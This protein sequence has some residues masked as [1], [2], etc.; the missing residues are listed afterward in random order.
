[1]KYL[2]CISCLLINIFL[3]SCSFQMRFFK[4]VN[5]AYLDK[6]LTISPLSAYQVLGL[7]ANGARGETLDQMLSTLGNQNLNELNLINANIIA[8]INSLSSVEIAN[9][10]MTRVKPKQAFMNAAVVYGATVESLR[11]VE[12]V[13]SWCN[14]K[15]HGTIPTIIDSL[16]PNTIMLLLNALYFKGTWRTEFDPKN[17]TKKEF[18][19]LDKTVKRVDT[20]L[21][22]EKLNY[23]EDKEV[24]VVELPYTKDSMSALILLPREGIN[25]NNFIDGLDDDKLQKYIKRMYEETV[26][27]KLPKFTLEFSAELNKVLQSMGM[28]LPFKGSADFTG[29][30][31]G[32]AYI[33]KVIQKTYLSVDEQGTEA[34]SA[35]V[36][37]INKGLPMVY[38]MSVNRPFLFMIRNKNLP[39]NYE[40]MFMAKVAQL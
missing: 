4:E 40:M 27:L 19:N 32:S 38:D 2:L 22:K 37:I 24:Q 11:S 12:Q 14:L 20:M 21:L 29:M 8:I 9:A 34:S 6:N 39:S 13:N 30:V 18:Y 7:T 28:I 31:D 36:V 15:T 23:Y 25:I 35:T 26:E 16:S 1:M 5:N 33:D 10:V 3:S 17:T